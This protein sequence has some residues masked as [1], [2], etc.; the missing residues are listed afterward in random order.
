[1]SKI[2]LM[3]VYYLLGGLALLYLA[4][5]CT[6][7]H[8]TNSDVKKHQDHH[9]KGSGSWNMNDPKKEE[10]EKPKDLEIKG[11]TTTEKGNPDPDSGGDSK[12]KGPK[13]GVYPDIYGPE[14]LVA[15]G[16]KDQSSDN[17]EP[18]D[19]LPAAEFP[20]GPNAPSPFLTDFS[21]LL[22]T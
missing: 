8:M 13:T 3:H 12:S 10:K 19:F 22:K 6:Y 2:N 7:E 14:V 20:A 16:H 9:A 1:M 4:C 18:Y 17:P 15:P 5:S 11:P 21:K